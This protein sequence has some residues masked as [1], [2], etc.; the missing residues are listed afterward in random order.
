[1]RKTL[2][3][4]VFPARAKCFWRRP[5]CKPFF[6][7]SFL[8]SANLGQSLSVHSLSVQGGRRQ[9]NTKNKQQPCGNRNKLTALPSEAER[10]RKQ[11]ALPTVAYPDGAPRHVLPT[12]TCQPRAAADALPYVIRFPFSSY[13][14]DKRFRGQR[15]VF[16]LNW[17]N[18]IVKNC[19]SYVVFGHF[20]MQ[21]KLFFH[22]SKISRTDE[23]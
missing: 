22:V 17:T 18:I 15:Y 1:M 10:Q 4:R 2:Q 11:I 9:T 16:Y 6:P 23:K 21:M 7:L 13:V 8:K 19:D 5:F 3:N 14:D 12:R 20:P